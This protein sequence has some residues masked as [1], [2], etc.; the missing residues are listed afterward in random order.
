MVVSLRLTLALAVP[1]ALA[2]LA[3][4]E[5]RFWT[6]MWISDA[7]IALVALLDAWAA[8]EP[9]VSVTREAPRVLS[10]GRP[11]AV[12]LIVRSRARRPLELSVIDELFEHASAD[13][14]PARVVLPP[15]GEVTVDYSVT[16]RRRGG[17]ELGPARV[18]YPSPLGL[19]RRQL[20][21]GERHPV[22]V[23]P[24]LL[25]LRTFELLARQNRELEFARV[26]RRRGGETEFSRLRDYS[27][28]D[29]YRSIDWKATARR[30]RLTAREYQL[31]SNQELLFMLDAGRMMTSE[32]NG[33]TQFDHALNAALMLG[34]VA[35]RTGD[36]V[37]MLV[38]DSALRAYLA[39]A[40]GNAAQN[41]LIASAYDLHPQLCESDYDTA[42][43]TLAI[44]QRKRALVVIFSQVLDDAVAGS[45]LRGVRALSR[46]HL[47]L[48]VLFRDLE[49]DALLQERAES[50]EALYVRAAAAELSSWRSSFIRDLRHGGALVLDVGPRELTGKL[51]NRYFEVKARHQL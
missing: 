50:R 4:I 27:P 12:R 1:A 38:F 26:T 39:P 24:D 37:G 28:D 43:R 40:R 49:L 45:M 3:L 20:E 18:R 16:P 17:Y 22:R 34:H 35:L 19:W 15:R 32:V 51:I 9:L 2:L 5:P 11:N 6:A 44:R 21:L 31:E 46:N 10:I 8:R 13:G 25:Q 23:Y 7:L 33:V 30:E 42:F 36:Q 14:L 47:P 41:R 48:V 29:E